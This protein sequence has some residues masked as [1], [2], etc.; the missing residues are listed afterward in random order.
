MTYYQEDKY[1]SATLKA[2]ELAA[3]Q[4]K[5][6]IVQFATYQLIPTLSDVELIESLQGPQNT[7]SN[8]AK[9]IVVGT[10]GV[11]EEGESATVPAD[12]M[13]PAPWSS[14]SSS[15]RSARP[16]RIF[17]PATARVRATARSSRST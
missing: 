14:P 15:R 6:I 2:L 13:M 3:N 7:T 17:G 10:V 16:P 1:P 12:R 8:P 9:G 5:G 4:A 11:W